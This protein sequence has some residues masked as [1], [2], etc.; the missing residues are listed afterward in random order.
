MKLPAFSFLP[1][2]IPVQKAGKKKESVRPDVEKQKNLFIPNLDYAMK[3]KIPFVYDV[4]INRVLKTSVVEKKEVVELLQSCDG[5]L[6][7][8]T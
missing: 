4:N 2:E 7:N 3:N 1:E 8:K 5:F 6:W